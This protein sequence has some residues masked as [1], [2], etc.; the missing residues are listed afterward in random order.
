[1]PTNSF[2]R[3]KTV[4]LGAICALAV[5]IG[6]ISTGSAQ[7]LQTQ[8]NFRALLEQRLKNTES[9]QL[10]SDFNSTEHFQ[11]E[12]SPSDENNAEPQP[13]PELPAVEGVDPTAESLRQ[14]LD[15]L[16]NSIDSNAPPSSLEYFEAQALVNHPQIRVLVYEIE[17]L[18]S[19]S[20]QQSLRPNPRLT[21]FGDEV[22]NEAKAG[23]WGARF[24]RT[25]V[26]EQKL[27][28]QSRVKCLEAETVVA[29][30]STVR[31]RIT[32][33]VRAA[34]Y[35][36]L[37][38]QRQIELASQL[39]ESY[40]AA[41]Q[42]VQ[43]MV[44]AGESTQAEVLQ[45]EVQYQQ[46]AARQ[47]NAKALYYSAW[48]QLAAVVGDETMVAQTVEGSLDAISAPLDFNDT[49]AKLVQSSP[50]I[51][52]ANANIQKAKA[53]LDREVATSLPVTQTQWTVGRDSVTNDF[54][55]GVQYSMPLQTNDRNQGNI[56]A[57][58]ARVAAAHQ[59]AELL[60]RKLA[61]RLAKEFQSYE[62]ASHRAEI[63]LDEILPKSRQ[64]VQMVS[65]AF[66]AGE[67]DF[68]QLLTA[69]RT[70][71]NAT[72]DYLVALQTVWSSRQRIEGL[73]L[74]DSLDNS[75]FPPNSGY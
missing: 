59:Q 50:E 42:Q 51:A 27:K 52:V 70:L 65:D 22:L 58:R 38:A 21:I 40:L 44:E 72:N 5:L 14:A 67:A 66:Q 1:M 28:A 69:Q 33:D 7:A 31:Q 49:L 9:N 23:L 64:A 43:R 37:I 41:I 48:R 62:V 3:F 25:N 24:T 17:A 47:S 61:S 18:R 54:Y 75:A 15:E 73:L 32:T 8:N 4:K 6:A 53:V 55:T 36:V 30:I 46:A 35:N 56:S 63:Y 57:A 13:V 26:P 71:I 29:Q 11:V 39:T 2:W 45:L 16:S 68:L 60:P 19:E 10:A 12:T 34:F 74:S 20:Y